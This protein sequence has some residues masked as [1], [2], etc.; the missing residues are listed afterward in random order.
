MRLIRRYFEEAWNRGNLRYIDEGFASD[1]VGHASGEEVDGPERLK[2]H[3][4]SRRTAHP[5]LQCTVE[6]MIAEADRV[7]VRWTA[8]DVQPGDPVTGQKRPITGMTIAR[9]AD[10]KIVES[11]SESET[12]AVL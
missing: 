12:L 3:V 9:L 7:A 10:G 6:D 8:R 2:E 1:W 4:S 5:H 11:W